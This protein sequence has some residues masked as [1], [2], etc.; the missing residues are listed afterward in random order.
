MRVFQEFVV[1]VK[2]I[3]SVE[4]VRAQA[5]GTY[6]HFVTYTSESTKEDRYSIYQ[7]EQNFYE[8]YPT[9]DLEFD[10]V[11]RQGYPMERDITIG[12]YIQTIRIL[13]TRYDE[14]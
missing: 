7:I 14:V 9:L 13:P 12:K 5:G 2:D 10:L 1:A 11:D 8:R 3:P 4:Q 6:L